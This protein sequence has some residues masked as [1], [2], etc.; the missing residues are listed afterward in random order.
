M[1]LLVFIIFILSMPF[2]NGALIILHIHNFDF[3][4]II[5]VLFCFHSFFIVVCFWIV[6]YCIVLYIC[7]LLCCSVVI[8]FSLLF[9][10]IKL[11]QPNFKLVVDYRFVVVFIY[12]LLVHVYL[13]FSSTCNLNNYQN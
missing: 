10:F 8:P 13:S 7:S 12:S 11:F 3:L 4:L 2:S 1:F 6:L 9:A 5:V